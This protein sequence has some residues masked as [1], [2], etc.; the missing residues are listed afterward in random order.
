MSFSQIRPRFKNGLNL[1]GQLKV[2]IISANG[3]NKSI[4]SEDMVDG[5]VTLDDLFI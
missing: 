1:R 2:C 5:V 4:H 3:L